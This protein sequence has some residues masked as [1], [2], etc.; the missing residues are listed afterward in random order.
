MTDIYRELANNDIS[1]DLVMCAWFGVEWRWELS[2]S[3]IRLC[4]K[5]WNFGRM[6]GIEDAMIRRAFNGQT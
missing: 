3:F 4:C 2:W 6:Y 1:F 5:G